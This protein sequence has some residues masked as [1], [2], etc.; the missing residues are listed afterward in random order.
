MLA[1]LKP[2]FRTG[3]YIGLVVAVGL[4][5]YLFQ[6]WEAGHQ[7]RLHS[8]HLLRALEKK[9]WSKVENFLDPAYADQWEHDRATVVTRLRQVLPYARNLRIHA[10]EVIVRAAEGEGDWRARVTLEAEPNEVS[11][12]IQQRVN[13][14]DAPFELRWR[15]VSK[16]PWD[17]KLVRV[18][19]PA[20]RLP[21]EPGF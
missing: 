7:V 18:T 13:T 8:E 16:K 1:S 9:Q 20:L 21:N 10:R 3:L 14:L 11:T 12:F 2:S 17:W 4:G 19:N 5:L 6:L 15:R